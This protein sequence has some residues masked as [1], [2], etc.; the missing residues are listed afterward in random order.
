MLD[1]RCCSEWRWEF[2]NCFRCSAR[3]LRRFCCLGRWRCMAAQSGICLDLG[4]FW[5]ALRQTIDQV[6]GPIVLGRA[7]RLPPVAVIFAFLAGGVLFG[8]LGLLV[9]IPAAALFKLLLDNYYALP[10]RVTAEGFTFP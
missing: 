4:A 3:L 8:I 1:T 2:W 10:N 7:V 5:F 9:A 6:V